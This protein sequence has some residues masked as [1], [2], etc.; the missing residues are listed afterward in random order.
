VAPIKKYRVKIHPQLYHGCYVARVVTKL[1]PQQFDR[2]LPSL[3]SSLD[4]SFNF[5]GPCTDPDPAEFNSHSPSLVL[6]FQYFTPLVI[7]V[8]PTYASFVGAILQH[9]FDPA[10]LINAY[11][12]GMVPTRTR[13]IRNSFFSGTTDASFASL[14]SL[15]IKLF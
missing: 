13:R 3:P 4:V 15:N 10:I 11:S 6:V 5:F 14:L 1:G 8:L 7:S 9:L 2:R 12:S